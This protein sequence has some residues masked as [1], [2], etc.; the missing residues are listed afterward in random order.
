MLRSR[1]TPLGRTGTTTA[2]RRESS[3]LH[4]HGLTGG[5]DSA[6]ADSKY[7]RDLSPETNCAKRPAHA[8]ELRTRPNRPGKP[9]SPPSKPQ[10]IATPATA[11]KKCN[12][13]SLTIQLG[14]KDRLEPNGP[15]IGRSEVTERTSA[16]TPTAK[17]AQDTPACY[18]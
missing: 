11:A 12:G 1:S 7:L 17:H 18:L 13:A 10:A 16:T 2:T 4:L 8:T 3:G 14:T 9:P 6:S 5:P 15:R